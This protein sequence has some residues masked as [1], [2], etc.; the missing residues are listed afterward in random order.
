MGVLHR[1][2]SE[3]YNALVEAR[4]PDLSPLSIQYKDYAAWHNA[5]LQSEAINTHKEYWSYR[6]I[7]HARR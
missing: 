3:L 4:T 2:F 7:N 6:V 1:E 5:Q